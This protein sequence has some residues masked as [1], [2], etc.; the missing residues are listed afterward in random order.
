MKE[1]EENKRRGMIEGE[2][3]DKSSPVTGRE[4]P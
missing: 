4:G 2:K 3:K 1:I